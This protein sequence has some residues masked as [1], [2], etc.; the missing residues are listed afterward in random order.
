MCFFTKLII[1]AL[2]NSFRK[3]I[4]PKNGSMER[5][6]YTSFEK[7]KQITFI[8]K[9]RSLNLQIIH[10]IVTRSKSFF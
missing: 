6:L 3:M 4:F 9:L 2:K 7:K 5:N 1:C 8:I 10:W